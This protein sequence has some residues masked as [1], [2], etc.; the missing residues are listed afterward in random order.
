M[1]NAVVWCYT[2][3]LICLLVFLGAMVQDLPERATVALDFLGMWLRWVGLVVLVFLGL[4]AVIIIYAL[5]SK[6]Q[7][8]AARPVDG[9]FPLQR[10]RIHIWPANTPFLPAFFSWLAGDE[11]FVN[12]NTMV[13]SAAIV[14]RDGFREL[15]PA[16]GW[17][18]QTE[19]RKQVE[20]TNRVRAM[21][22]G[23]AA[24]MDR[25]GSMSH[26]P[27]ASAG[28]LR[29]VARPALPGPNASPMPSQQDAIAEGQYRW[30]A[31]DA[32][33][34]NTATSFALGLTRDNSIVNWD[35][36]TAPHLRVH[37]QSQGSGKTTLIKTLAT[38]VLRAGHRA[39]VLDR[40]QFKDWSSFRP[41]IEAVDNMQP[42]AFLGT[43]TQIEQLYLSRDRRLGAAGAGNVARLGDERVFLI[44]SEFGSACRMAKANG[45][46]EEIER[47][48]KNIM[49]ESASTGVHLV[50][51]DQV[52]DG[53][54]PA[55]VRGNADV[56]TGYLP[57]DSARAGGYNKAYKLRG[58][59]FHYGGAIFK[60]WNIEL[61]AADLLRGVQPA[62]ARLINPSSFLPS[63]GARD[64]QNAAENT[65]MQEGRKEGRIIGDTE[66]Q[67]MIWDWRD[68]KRGSQAAFIRYLRETTGQTVTDGYVS[69][70]WNRPN[71][72]GSPVGD[73]PDPSAPTELTTYERLR[74]EFGEDVYIG[75]ERL[76][77]DRASKRA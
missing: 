42:G 40:R 63:L 5:Y 20:V 47:V 29:E 10:R 70:V 55:V 34:Q 37:G 35:I 28:L 11:V 72:S 23:D 27:R 54:W 15:E 48:L 53:N 67:R 31:V 62:P 4:A 44:I 65:I 38:G 18:R 76:G 26:S 3:T 6:F 46:Y 74:L 39:I 57:E 45:D 2:I 41:Y 21:F 58:Y 49:A 73:Q 1:K 7:L 17:E 69:K 77:T 32:I 71:A 75:N 56:V 36:F 30:M 59:K 33:K 68:N 25:H 9:A 13:G 16:A 51:E 64:A 19:V 52:R 8:R 24:R 12:I 60:S 14:N 22:P 66:L 50:F 61:E 43:L